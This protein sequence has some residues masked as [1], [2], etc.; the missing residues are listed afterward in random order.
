MVAVN[1]MKPPVKTMLPSHH[2]RRCIISNCKGGTNRQDVQ[3]HNTSALC[4][5]LH[6]RALQRL[7]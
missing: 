6:F 3:Q 4:C 7:L 2:V 1:R 5:L